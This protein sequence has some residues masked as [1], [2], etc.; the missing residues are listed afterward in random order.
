[1]PAPSVSNTVASVPPAGVLPADI[2]STDSVPEPFV[3][4]PGV[5]AGAITA[6]RSDLDGAPRRVGARRARGARAASREMASRDEPVEDWERAA[7]AAA[8]HECR[9]FEAFHALH[10]Q[11]RCPG[12]LFRLQTRRDFRTL[13]DRGADSSPAGYG[14]RQ[15]RVLAKRGIACRRSWTAARAL[16]AEIGLVGSSDPATDDAVSVGES[17]I[18]CPDG[19]VPGG[20]VPGD[21]TTGDASVEDEPV[22]D[23]PVRG[24]AGEACPRSTSRPSTGCSAG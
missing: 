1:M 18:S 15:R 9:L 10:E 8:A 6:G 16:V 19:D 3:L 17:D 4:P 7:F 12:L 13:C 14:D 24:R 23:E 20:D 5:F 21:E 2:L 11:A 22:Q